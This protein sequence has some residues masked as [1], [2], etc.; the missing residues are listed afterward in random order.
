MTGAP[1]G[2]E[3]GVRAESR[4]VRHV[5]EGG[6]GWPSK[7]CASH[8]PPPT[9]SSVPL[10]GGS[11]L[12]VSVAITGAEQAAPS[13]AGGLNAGLTTAAGSAAA[14]GGAADATQRAAIHL[15]VAAAAAT[16]AL[17][18]TLQ[19]S[20]SLEPPA[21]AVRAAHRAFRAIDIQ[22]KVAQAGE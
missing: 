18:T 6:A 12:A 17:V 10:P 16:T 11:S 20:L 13:L 4:N 14:R 8:V 1:R 9:R 21:G 5:G 2:E 22:W 15:R 19:P 3:V 7:I